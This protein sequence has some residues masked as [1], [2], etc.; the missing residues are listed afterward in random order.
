MTDQPPPEQPPA[1]PPGANPGRQGIPSPPSIPPRSTSGP[2]PAAGP[3][4]V[5]HQQADGQQQACSQPAGSY[6]GSQPQQGTY[7]YPTGPWPARQSPIDGLTIREGLVTA[8]IGLAAGFIASLI[9]SLIVVSTINDAITDAADGMPTGSLGFTLPFILFAL[10]LGGSAA[11]RFSGQAFDEL[12]ASAAVHFAGAPL[13]I[14]AV[15]TTALVWWSM[16][17]ERRHPSRTVAAFWIRIGLT[18]LSLTT[19]LFLLQLIF[20]SRSNITEDYFSASLEFSAVTPRTFFLPLIFIL[21][22]TT[23][24]RILGHYRGCDAA[25]LPWLRYAAAPARTALLHLVI[26]GAIFLI[27]SFFVLPLHFDVHGSFVPLLAGTAA[28]MMAA[29]THFGGLSASGRALAGDSH[30]G[31]S[32]AVT[33]FSDTIPGTLWLGL[34]AVLLAAFIAAI[35]AAVTRRPSWAHQPGV[36]SPWTSIWQLPVTFGLLW[37]LLSV[38]LLPVKVSG[39]ASGQGAD[40]LGSDIPAMLNLS[41]GLLPW[42]FLIFALWGLLIEVLAI[43]IAPRIALTMPQLAAWLGGRAVHPYWGQPL[44]I[45]EPRGA[46]RH[47]DMKTPPPPV[48]PPGGSATPPPPSTPPATSA[49]AA[50]AAPYTASGPVQA[51][52]PPP[53]AM[54]AGAMPPP[55]AAPPPP[56]GYAAAPMG[57]PQPIDRRKAK[58]WGI[59]AG[60]L[61]LALVASIIAVGQ[62]NSRFYGPDGVVRSY[63]SKLSSGDAE[64]ALALADVDVPVEERTLLTNEVLGN[65]AARPDSI[66]ITDTEVDGDTAVVTAE[67]DLGGSKSDVTMDVRKVGKRGIFFNDWRLA[68][69]GLGQVV[70]ETPNLSQVNVN[71]VTVPTADGMLSLPA[72]PALYTVSLTDSSDYLEADEVQTRAFFEG[73]SAEEAG[74][75]LPVLQATPTQAFTDEVN[76]QVRSLLDSC[77]GKAETEPAGCPFGSRSASYSDVTNVK[78]SIEEYPGI[79]LSDSGGYGYGYGDSEPNDGSK[80]RI[81]SESTGSALITG[82]YSLFG[83]SESYDNTVSFDVSGTAEIVDGKVVI[84]VEENSGY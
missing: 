43:T 65:A 59:A 10:A 38:V 49:P 17:S 34:L 78:W 70:V 37:G 71:G 56:P 72:F 13:L 8:A 28:L 42:T 22:A 21:I 64:G 67:F 15:F 2:Q 32:T 44:G 82:T 83:D 77:A 11:L 84:S 55:G 69:P 62:I 61:V 29:L 1:N 41:V 52:P 73:T 58:I 4:P 19:V 74:G 3:Q 6:L 40:L 18:T 75:E 33:M 81:T 12:S 68:S 14:T 80:W 50:A 35:A 16:F 60:A 66:S 39:R 45:S 48:A 25:G 53:N 36:S 7:S 24:G 31:G 54:P 23:I 5:Y 9:I 79:S 20:A 76:K 26:V 51:T 47:P 30:E 46:L 63:L 57:P 27:V